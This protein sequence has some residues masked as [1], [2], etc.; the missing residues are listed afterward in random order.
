MTE[1]EIKALQKKADNADELAKTLEALQKSVESL[2]SKNREILNEK[3]T[4]KKKAE[5][6]AAEAARKA[7]D[8]E[9]L[10]SSWKQKL[11]NETEARDAQI[12]EYRNMVSAMTVGAE[13][14]RLASELALPGSAEAL[15]PHIERR[16]TVEVKEGKP[17]VR[18]LGEDGKPSASSI[19][20][21]RKEIEASKA[22]APILVGSNASG[23]GNVGGKGGNAG[24]KTISREAF[25]ALPHPER[26]AFIKDGGKLTE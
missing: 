9:S 21:L 25:D 12:A 1:E 6:A 26:A 7:G 10:E 22:L 4:A 20:D 16:L 24:A 14:T 17:I 3:A 13:A 11:Q 23:S 18:V 15:L 19:E 5:E 2:E 8:V